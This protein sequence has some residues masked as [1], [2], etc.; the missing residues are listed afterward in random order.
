MVSK[1]QIK[2]V[3]S[4]HQKKYR[5]R[6]NLFVAEG[7]KVVSELVA[8]DFKVN[9]VYSTDAEIEVGAAGLVELV[10]EVELKKMSALTTPNKVLGVFEIPKARKPDLTGWV[11]VLDDVR[12]P[13]NLG[14]II[15]LCDWFGIEHL[16]CSL[17]TVDCYNPKTLQA[18]MGSI[19]RVNIGYTDLP[20]F[21]E[22][23]PS[24]IYGAFMDGVSV[25]TKAMPESGILVMGNEANGVSKE[26]EALVSR[27]ISIPQFGKNTTESLNVATATAIL[28]NEI[29]RG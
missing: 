28:L 2:L 24:D 17:N 11:L 16:V 25:Y 8:S 26:V 10:S 6:H 9:A 18:T 4:L 15:R 13:G 19:S 14:T 21:L 27:K 20:T 5:N 7:I 3:K 23:V 1:N 22:G 12:D 29:R